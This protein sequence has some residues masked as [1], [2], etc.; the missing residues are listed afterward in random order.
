MRDT[1]YMTYGGMRDWVF[2]VVHDIKGFGGIG[3]SG[4]GSGCG[5]LLWWWGRIGL[6]FGAVGDGGTRAAD[7]LDFT[8]LL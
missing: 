1:S 4:S 2:Y 5:G 3:F 6:G 7:L 8:L